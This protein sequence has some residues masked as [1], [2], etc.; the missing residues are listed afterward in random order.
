MGRKTGTVVLGCN[1]L[2][3]P[4]ALGW[5]QSVSPSCLGA[6]VWMG[7]GAQA[8]PSAAMARGLAGF[9]SKTALLVPSFIHLEET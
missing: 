7:T 5:G 9:P 3:V 1:V 4:L 2:P 6:L 8:G